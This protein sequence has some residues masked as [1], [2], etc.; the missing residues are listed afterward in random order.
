MSKT[1]SAFIKI[2]YLLLFLFFG[3]SAVY[4][5]NHQPALDTGPSAGSIGSANCDLC[6]FCSG[7]PID[8]APTDWKKCAQCLYP[9]VYGGKDSVPDQ[10]DGATLRINPQNNEPPAPRKGAIYTF[11]GCINTNIGS[12][13]DE[14]AA[15]SVTAA[16]LNIIFK[17]AGVLSFIYLVYAGFLILTSQGNPEK[18]RQGK[19]TL[20][21][22]LIGLGISL[23]AVF[24]IS[25]I[26]S[27]LGIEL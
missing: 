25:L 4:A 24:I 1:K 18:L 27:F 12:F 10:P 5:S 14:G 20:I 7:T 15:V 23:A 8:E 17:L 9:D 6:G 26:T 3:V 22:S 11:L 16:L 2:F 19:R 21:R 13:Q